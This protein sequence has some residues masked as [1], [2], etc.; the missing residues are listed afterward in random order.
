[1]Q[2]PQQT[3]AS[4]A[5]ARKR[6]GG[7]GAWR[8][9]IHSRCKRQKVTDFASLSQEYAALGADEKMEFK[10]LGAAATASHNLGG[11]S[12]PAFSV[13]ARRSRD[14]RCSERRVLPSLTPHTISEIDNLSK[15][16]VVV[17]SKTLD[18]ALQLQKLEDKTDVFIDL[19]RVLAREDRQA[20]KVQREEA[21]R[22]EA[23][24]LEATQ[25]ETSIIQ[26]RAGLRDMTSCQ[27]RPYPH[28]CPAAHAV[29]EPK[30]MATQDEDVGTLSAQWHV[31]H[32]GLEKS[33]WKHAARAPKQ[34]CFRSSFCRCRGRGRSLGKIHAVV[35]RCVRQF[36][37]DKEVEAQLLSGQLIMQLQKVVWQQPPGHDQTAD[38]AAASPIEGRPV[39]EE[40]ELPV[41]HFGYIAL[42]YLKPWRPTMVCLRTSSPAATL[43]QCAVVQTQEGAVEAAPHMPEH[44]ASFHCT[45]VDEAPHLAT[46]WEFLDSTITLQHTWWMKLW[47][48][49]E[50][51]TPVT[52][53]SNTLW[54]RPCRLPAVQIWSPQ[55]PRRRRRRG[56]AAVQQRQAFHQVFEAMHHDDDEERL[57]EGPGA[58]RQE[59]NEADEDD[60]DVLLQFADRTSTS[61][62]EVVEL[63]DAIADLAARDAGAA[64]AALPAASHPAPAQ[65][66]EGGA[67]AQ[68]SSS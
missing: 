27:W 35:M 66:A 3:S 56:A 45:M 65:A 22:R 25:T 9:F 52:S 57:A 20:R 43:Q 42:Q 1:M 6:R 36:C 7:G 8:A 4:T 16:G 29:C 24:I 49:S 40:S 33:K 62:G 53:L 23:Q 19:V 32:L 34:I 11:A 68:S 64:E 54:A 13:R 44:H 14:G 17:S 28:L 58:I 55:D 2:E 31:R 37:E 60:D 61:E 38:H 59:E 63:R 30:H 21:L 12:F 41:S 48:A 50:R 46:V 67:G 51:H 5:P 39:M 15:T 10:I 26:D 47:E 18:E